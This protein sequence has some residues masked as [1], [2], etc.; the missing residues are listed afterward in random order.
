MTAAALIAPW[1][2]RAVLFLRHL[3]SVLILTRETLY[4]V[5]VGPFRGKP[6][7]WRTVI[8]HMDEAG[9]KS[10]PIVIIIGFFTGVILAMQAA[11]QLK[12]IGVTEMVGP[13]VTVSLVR[14][15]GPMMV[16]IIVAGRVGAAFTAEI[17]TMKVSEEILALETMAVNPVEFL[18]TPRFIALFFMLPCLSVLADLVGML[19]GMFI[20]VTSLQMDAGYY[21][22]LSLKALFLR[23]ILTGVGKTFV[24]AVIIVMVGCYQA[25]VVE[26]GAEGV[27][28]ATMVAV[29]V[30]LVL[31]VV[32]DAMFAT[33]FYFV[34]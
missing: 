26:G 19:G 18:I 17:G 33:L 14:E 8:H 29:V 21:W 34:F 15:L 24:F 22:H 9:V 1:K 7:R 11:Y 16:A 2:D 20:A 10:L 3:S 32:S 12:Q 28:R 4:W 25:F 13:L 5:V 6:W 27:G 31:I 30:S 23:D